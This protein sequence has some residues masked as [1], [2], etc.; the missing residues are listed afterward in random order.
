MRNWAAAENDV[1]LPNNPAA[2]AATY[3]PCPG[4]GG[5]LLSISANASRKSR[6]RALTEKNQ[7]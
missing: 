1:L 3:A 6:E 4:R 5:R 2:M 7:Y